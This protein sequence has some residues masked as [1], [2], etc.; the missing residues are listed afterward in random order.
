MQS[1]HEPEASILPGN[2]LEMQNPHTYWARID[3]ST[4]FLGDLNAY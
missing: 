4:K 3:I 2:L 1:V